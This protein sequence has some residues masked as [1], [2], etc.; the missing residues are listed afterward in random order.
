MPLKA[1]GFVSGHRFS[2]AA[3]ASKSDAPLGAGQKVYFSKLPTACNFL[4]APA[5]YT[6]AE[7]KQ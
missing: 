1:L 5:S 7:D 2:D 3:N 6:Y 4:P